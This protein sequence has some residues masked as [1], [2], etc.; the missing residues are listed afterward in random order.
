MGLQ[1]LNS[2]LREK[3]GRR[4]SNNLVDERHMTLPNLKDEQGPDKVV[5]N[6]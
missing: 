2:H 5:G 4:D 6:S 3:E 1:S